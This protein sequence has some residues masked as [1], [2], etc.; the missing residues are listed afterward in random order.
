MENDTPE[1]VS[2]TVTFFV[3][4]KT[5][6]AA[7]WPLCPFP[8]T[9]LYR[10]LTQSNQLI[11]KEWWMH[12]VDIYKKFS[13]LKSHNY[14]SEDLARMAMEGFYAFGSII[15]RTC[16]FKVHRFISLVV[17]LNARWKLK[18]YRVSTII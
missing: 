7:F 8:G 18:K 3:E 11:E 16:P 4:N 17:N 1:T 2:N 14:I 10:K 15:K 13:A 5:P 9:E 12:E 6:I